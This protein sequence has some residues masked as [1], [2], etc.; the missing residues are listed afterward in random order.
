MKQIKELQKVSETDG[1]RVVRIH[2]QGAIKA[3]SSAPII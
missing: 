2:C 1:N 3:A